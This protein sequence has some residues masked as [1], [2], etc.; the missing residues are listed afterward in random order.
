MPLAM[1]VDDD[2]LTARAMRDGLVRAGIGAE[3]CFGAPD[4]LARLERGGVDLVLLDV[5]LPGASGIDVCAEITRRWPALDV[6]VMSAYASSDR[7][8]AAVRAGAHDFLTKPISAESLAQ[9]VV[10]LT[11]SRAA[12]ER[13]AGA[14]ARP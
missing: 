13:G 4:A 8:Q 2:E 1:V 10:R 6:L 3:V 7:A 5:H 9:R 11:S 14:G 12:R